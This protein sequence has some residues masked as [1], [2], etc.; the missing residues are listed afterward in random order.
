[1]ASPAPLYGAFFLGPASIPSVSLRGPCFSLLLPACLLPFWPCCQRPLVLGWL[2]GRAWPLKA[3]QALGS[4]RD[5]LGLACGERRR[6]KGLLEVLLRSPFCSLMLRVSPL[7]SSPFPQVE[8]WSCSQMKV[9]LIP[10][11][12]KRSEQPFASS[13]CLYRV[14][15][16]FPRAKAPT[17]SQCLLG[18]RH[19][20]QSVS[21]YLQS[22]FY[23]AQHS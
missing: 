20:S 23:S 6:E 12:R 7:L 9:N 1:M 16:G 10:S 11:W 18:T 17:G 3:T 5:T 8:Q 21:L 19:H 4:L 13:F 22:F 2:R 14:I 15:H